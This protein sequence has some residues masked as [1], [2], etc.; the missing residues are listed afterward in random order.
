[1]KKVILFILVS[2]FLI[3]CSSEKKT[4]VAQKSDDIKSKDGVIIHE[5]STKP[6]D[7]NFD[8]EFT[9]AFRIKADEETTEG[10][11][12][13]NNLNTVLFDK[14]NNVYALDYDEC[15]IYK[16]S[17]D[18]KFI[19]K[20]GGKGQGPGE[21]QYPN[22]ITL[23]KDKFIIVS[24]PMMNRYVKFTLDGEFIENMTQPDN[25]SITNLTEFDNYILGS[26]SSY[27]TFIEGDF[28][29]K[30][31][32]KL[33]DDSLKTVKSLYENNKKVEFDKQTH[34]SEMHLR[35]AVSKDRL[36]LPLMSEDEFLIDVY[37]KNGNIVEKIKKD[38]RRV[39]FT[40]EE[41]ERY[42]KSYSYAFSV[43]G[44]TKTIDF[45]ATFKKAITNIF[46]DKY[47]RLWVKES[48]KERRVYSIYKN[49]KYIGDIDLNK[50]IDD[51]EEDEGFNFVLNNNSDYLIIYDYNSNELIFY[52]YK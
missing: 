29:M 20:F 27:F 21:F 13:I 41:I 49:G 24:A 10:L 28:V 42:K 45:G 16:F 44:E 1:M 11:V 2:L 22:S 33:Y 7:P 15:K 26:S 25:D 40:E 39:A 38:Y 51:K 43:N 8:I 46:I 52:S 9:E 31:F 3:S 37:D 35:Y 5:N 48:G 19:K 50:L 36:Y 23:Y 32:I 18:G 4:E 34:P 6:Q 12:T 47:D 17:P 14:D 30:S